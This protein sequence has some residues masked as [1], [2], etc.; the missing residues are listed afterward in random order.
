V[1]SPGDELAQPHERSRG[2]CGSV[3]VVPRWR[4]E[5]GPLLAEF[6]PFPFLQGRV[7]VV[8]QGLG[9]EGGGRVDKVVVDH[10]H[11]S[12]PESEG[13]RSGSHRIHQQ[14]VPLRR[15]RSG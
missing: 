15:D 8:H 12:Q 7:G 6:T 3:Q 10:G 13:N 2:H 4:E 5:G 9:R 1:D 11:S 14:V